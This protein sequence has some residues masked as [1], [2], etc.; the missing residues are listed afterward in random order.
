MTQFTQSYMGMNGVIKQPG[1]IP[2]E[3]PMNS[4]STPK[5]QEWPVYTHDTSQAFYNAGSREIK[6]ISGRTKVVIYGASAQEFIAYCERNDAGE[7]WQQIQRSIDPAQ[8][9]ILTRAA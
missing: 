6:W 9:Q 3:N 2:N 7:S 5:H 8:S 1:V 4:V